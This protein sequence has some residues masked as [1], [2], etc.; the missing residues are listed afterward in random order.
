M[1]RGRTYG[2]RRT[3]SSSIRRMRR[4]PRA[5]ELG[6]LTPTIPAVTVRPNSR[7]ACPSAVKIA[8]AVSVRI[9][10]H[11]VDGLV[12]GAHPDD[13][14]DGAEHLVVV[15]AHSRTDVVDQ[16]RAHEVA[17]G[18]PVDLQPAPVDDDR[19]A[20]AY[21]GVE[22]AL[23]TRPCLGA[24][25]RAHL[26]VRPV[27]RAHDEAAQAFG[28]L[29]CETV[30][31]VSDRDRHGD[32]HAALSRWTRRPPRSARPRPGPGRRRGARRHG[33]SRRRTPAHACCSAF[34]AG[35]RSARRVWTRRN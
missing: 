12:Q 11:Q 5:P 24:D 34:R 16:C 30:A 35:R 31:R 20:V 13:R 25:Q 7:A 33:S 1:P 15:N 3:L 14:E 32:R 10:V 26:G 23:G 27:G 21:G 8:A 9:R 18:V 28:D 2:A 17:T 29:L 6:T 19:R 4:R 22:V